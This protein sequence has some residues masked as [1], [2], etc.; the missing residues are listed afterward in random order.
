LSILKNWHKDKINNDENIHTID[1]QSP[2]YATLRDYTTDPEK[3]ITKENDKNLFESLSLSKN[4]ILR[5]SAQENEQFSTDIQNL[6]QLITNADF[7]ERLQSY[8]TIKPSDEF[9]TQRHNILQIL[10]AANRT[11][12]ESITLFLQLF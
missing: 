8:L 2:F 3:K 4:T 1:A 9:S 12:P 5:N 10:N 11:K 7:N 6:Q